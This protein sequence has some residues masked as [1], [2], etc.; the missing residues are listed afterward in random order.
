MLLALKK[1]IQL[2]KPFNRSEDSKVSKL[3][4]TILNDFSM[5]IAF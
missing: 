2:F 1:N 5:I 3:T 4:K